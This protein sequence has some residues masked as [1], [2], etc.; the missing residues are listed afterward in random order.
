MM[1][2]TMQIP[3]SVVEAMGEGGPVAPGSGDRV[4]FTVEAEV[5][6]GGD[7]GMLTVRPVSVNGEPL[8][9]GYGGGGEGME[10]MPE[11]E[12]EMERNNLLKMAQDEELE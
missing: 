12:D 6:D 11:S 5:V 1:G 2:N 3:A 9:G 4:S 10:N 7:G 8:G